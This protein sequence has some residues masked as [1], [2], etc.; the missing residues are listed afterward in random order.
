MFYLQFQDVEA[1]RR[2]SNLREVPSSI[3]AN[4]EQPALDVDVA[5]GL[6]ELTQAHKVSLEPRDEVDVGQLAML[7]TLADSRMVPR[8][9]IS[10]MESC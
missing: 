2:A 8:P 5:S 4:L 3:I 9:L 7:A 6:I 10:T 1:V